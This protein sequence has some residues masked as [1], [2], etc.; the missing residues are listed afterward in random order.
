MRSDDRDLLARSVRMRVRLLGR[1]LALF[2]LYALALAAIGTRHASQGQTGFNA[3]L[4]ELLGVTL[5]FIAAAAFLV[6]HRPKA[7]LE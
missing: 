1:M 4:I 3:G 7:P 5:L 6:I 2:G